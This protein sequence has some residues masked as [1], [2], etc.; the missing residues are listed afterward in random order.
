VTCRRDAHRDAATTRIV[1]LLCLLC[2]S[3]P[4]LILT[5][6]MGTASA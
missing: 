2:A 1:R 3:I 5:L 6:G 4:A